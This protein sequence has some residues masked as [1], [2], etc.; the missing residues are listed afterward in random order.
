[1][2]TLK[3]AI[4]SVE[5]KLGKVDN[6]KLLLNAGQGMS[7]PVKAELLEI[8][9]GIASGKFLPRKQFLERNLQKATIGA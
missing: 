4:N 7:D 8:G 1:M 5:G 2:E 9:E 3:H 6:I